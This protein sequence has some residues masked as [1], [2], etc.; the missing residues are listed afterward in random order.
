MKLRTFS[1]QKVGVRWNFITNKP[2]DFALHGVGCGKKV[3]K[4]GPGRDF[5][6][7]ADIQYFANTYTLKAG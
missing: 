7:G 6:T 1:I 3:E 4:Q 5:L 2:W